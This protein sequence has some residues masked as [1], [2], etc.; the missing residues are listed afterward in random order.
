MRNSVSCEMP[1]PL[2]IAITERQKLAARLP[3]VMI[4][5]SMQICRKKATQYIGAAVLDVIRSAFAMKNVVSYRND[6]N[7]HH[8]CEL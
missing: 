6:V 4:R 5:H 2:P 1:H 7:I 3:D 8:F